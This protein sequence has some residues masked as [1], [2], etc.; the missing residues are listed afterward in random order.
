VTVRG[1]ATRANVAPGHMVEFRSDCRT[2][3]DAPLQQRLP[4][5]PLYGAGENAQ[6]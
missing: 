6:S 1:G 4:D 5:R 3:I 2:E